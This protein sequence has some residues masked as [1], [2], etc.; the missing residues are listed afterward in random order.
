MDSS[1]NS[2][3]AV[4]MVTRA[5]EL[6]LAASF[7][8]FAAGVLALAVSATGAANRPSIWFTSVAAGLALFGAGAL[9]GG[10]LRRPLR[11]LVSS[12]IGF[13]V[14]LAI[15]GFLESQP[16][17]W[18]VGW[19]GRLL[20]PAGLVVGLAF[21][22][23]KT[24]SLSILCKECAAASPMTWIQG[25]LCTLLTVLA[26]MPAADQ[27]SAE[28][29]Q[30]VAEID[31]RDVGV[32]PGGAVRR[33]EFPVRNR[34]RTAMKVGRIMS[35]CGCMSAVA[36]KDGLLP[37]EA[38]SIIVNFTAPTVPG[39]FNITLVAGAS[40]KALHLPL[41][42]RGTAAAPELRVG[43]TRIDLGVVAP[44]EVREFSASL[45]NQGPA[46]LDVK[47][48]PTQGLRPIGWKDRT[49]APGET[50]RLYGQVQAPSEIGAWQGPSVLLEYDGQWGR[51]AIIPVSASVR[52][53]FEAIPPTL[54]IPV[55]A[56][57]GG[58][59][60]R[61]IRI[62]S[63]D[64]AQISPGILRAESSIKG[65]RV[66]MAG[67]D[68]L[69]VFL[70]PNTAGLWTGSTSGELRVWVSDNGGSTPIAVPVSVLTSIPKGVNP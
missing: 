25:A 3:V 17:W 1:E 54:A 50:V 10:I 36:Q 68:R 31:E 65:L 24:H 67:P 28:T 35:P 4:K 15:R 53:R 40:E 5:G 34:G 56:G 22:L 12:F 44:D 38:T 41:R 6:G 11:A 30:F 63:N 26:W 23:S 61:Q 19:H 62:A 69:R 70:E 66:E 46:P 13:L 43:P 27:G 20:M 45:T 29:R 8:L 7:G 9:A 58:A 57:P 52:R 42:I 32:V 14:I 55:S 33:L 60:E 48:P 21:L 2:K 37:G 47:W 39:D 59:S 64:G 51:Q 16:P 49:V 18:L